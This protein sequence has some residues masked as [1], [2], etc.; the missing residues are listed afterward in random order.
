[1]AQAVLEVLAERLGAIAKV[2]EMAGSDDE[3]LSRCWGKRA[4]KG[5]RNGG[6]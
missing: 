5:H 6:S 3:A 4:K 1:M 2:A